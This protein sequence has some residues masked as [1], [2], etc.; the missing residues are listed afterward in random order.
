M[1]NSPPITGARARAI[2]AFTHI[3][4]EASAFARSTKMGNTRASESGTSKVPALTLFFCINHSNTSRLQ[5]AIAIDVSTMGIS[6]NVFWHQT[7]FSGYRAILKNQCF[8]FS[9]SN[10]KGIS[11]EKGTENTPEYAYPMVSFCHLPLAD[12]APFVGRYGQ[13]MIGMKN[14][15]ATKNGLSPVVY[16]HDKSALAISLLTDSNDVDESSLL[17]YIKSYEEE[18]NSKGYKRYRF[19]NERE[20]R[21]LFSKKQCSAIG[22]KF[23]LSKDEYMEYKEKHKQQSLLPENAKLDFTPHDIAYIIIKTHGSHIDKCYADLIEVNSDIKIL[24]VVELMQDVIGVNHDVRMSEAQIAENHREKYRKEHPFDMSNIKVHLYDDPDI[25][26]FHKK[27]MD[28]AYDWSYYQRIGYELANQEDDILKDIEIQITTSKA[29]RNYIPDFSKN[30]F[31]L[32]VSSSGNNTDFT[33]MQKKRFLA[34]EIGALFY[35]GSFDLIG[36]NI[37]IRN[38]NINKPQSL[39]GNCN[40]D[41]FQNLLE[42]IIKNLKSNQPITNI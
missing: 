21:V 8:R 30:I 12:L 16:I 4:R 28:F 26:E 24:T 37:V 1:Y 32:K 11:N 13:Y 25:R 34:D 6:S 5:G 18:L 27:L 41:R 42:T 19:Y 3:L 40:M 7:S 2:G 10:E 35:S 23:A 33:D 15:W 9:Y 31:L 38:F 14:K 17:P 39:C 29:L 22:E 20:F 36:D